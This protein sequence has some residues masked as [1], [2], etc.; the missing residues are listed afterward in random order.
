MNMKGSKKRR[1]KHLV[2]SRASDQT[3]LLGVKLGLSMDSDLNLQGHIKITVRSAFYHPN[4]FYRN[5]KLMSLENLEFTAA[6][7]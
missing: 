7:E 1:K 6:F 2:Q 4:N 5:R 3:D